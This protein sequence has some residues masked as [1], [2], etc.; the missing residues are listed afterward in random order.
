MLDS[1]LYPEFLDRVAVV[2]GL[3]RRIQQG[4]LDT[5]L[6]LCKRLAD[7]NLI[8]PSLVVNLHTNKVAQIPG[9]VENND[10]FLRIALYQGDR[11][12]KKI[13]D[14][15]STHKEDTTVAS[16]VVNIVEAQST[17]QSYTVDV[18]DEAQIVEAQ[19]AAKQGEEAR[20]PIRD[21]AGPTSIP[22]DNFGLEDF[23]FPKEIPSD[24]EPYL[25]KLNYPTHVAYPEDSVERTLI[26]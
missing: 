20:N 19:R 16:K 18:V 8:G 2:Q 25:S 22:I 10:R 17:Q 13:T 7:A 6:T 5:Y 3:S 24:E 21:G 11:S 12:S 26:P 4:N 9:K 14:A 23:V 1:G 15:Q